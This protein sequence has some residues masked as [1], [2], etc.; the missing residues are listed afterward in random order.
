MAI[1]TQAAPPPA[2]LCP[3]APEDRIFPL[4][5][6]QYHEMV[7]HG[8]LA[9]DDPVELLD[10]LLIT[11]TSKSPA[12]R[13]AT[14]RVRDALEQVLATWTGTASYSARTAAL[15]ST[16]AAKISGHTGRD[17]LTGGCG[18]DWFFANLGKVPP[19]Q[20]LDWVSGVELVFDLGKKH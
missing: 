6:Q 15:V 4:S 20:L 7:R 17:E 3:P 16:L 12:H 1:S 18:Q 8:I 19:D 9:E 11:R 5:V 2:P 14:R 13:R 10:G